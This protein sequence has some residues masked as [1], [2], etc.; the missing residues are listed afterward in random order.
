MNNIVQ[1]LKGI[2]MQNIKQVV[3]RLKEI[4]KLDSNVDLANYLGVSYNTLNTWI[5]REKIPQEVLFEFC[6]KN[7]CSLDYL[8]FNTKNSQT[9]NLFST[10]ENS[11][12]DWHAYYGE[13]IDLQIKFKSKLK[14]NNNLLQNGGYYLVKYNKIE[15]ITKALFKINSNNLELIYNSQTTTIT[16]DEFKNINLGLIIDIENTNN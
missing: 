10:Q 14:L 1:T 13:F 8:L 15:F 11:N 12:D 3:S 2:K 7:N 9:T 6:K 4:A 16:F 5:K